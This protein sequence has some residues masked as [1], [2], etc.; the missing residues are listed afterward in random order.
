MNAHLYDKQLIGYVHFTLDDGERETMDSHL[1][2]CADCR[3]RLGE[4]ETLQRRV[5]YSL[6]A[7]IKAAPVP[8]TMTFDAIAPR[9]K[10]ERW[11]DRLSTPSSQFVPGATAFAALAG[12]AVA[13]IS[14]LQVA[15]WRDTAPVPVSP[16]RLPLL[17]CG[18]F[19]VAVMGNV[20]W[21]R[22]FPKREA[23]VRLV[24]FSLWLGTAIVGLQAIVTVL[25][26]ATWF[27]YSGVSANTAAL[28]AWVLIPLSIAWIA[29]VVGGGEYHYEHVGQRESW[30]LF[31]VTVGVE[32]LILVSPFILDVWFALPP[33]WR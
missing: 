3:T 13:L 25:D 16:G 19:A 7:D 12:L 29:I 2:V 18:W 31:G 33:I 11:W 24:A 30:R 15:G 14:A 10:R 23:L 27:L 28:G 21:T 17:A 9:L 32:L 4:Y 1:Q 26:L 8:A 22:R 5:R 6:S 20:G